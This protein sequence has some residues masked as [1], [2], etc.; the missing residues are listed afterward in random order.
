MEMTNR[1]LIAKGVNCRLANAKSH[2]VSVLTILSFVL[3]AGCSFT[4][5]ETAGVVFATM[6]SPGNKDHVILSS[7]QVVLCQCAEWQWTEIVILG[8]LV[9]PGG[10]RGSH[11]PISIMRKEY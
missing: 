7:R 1:W 10:I 6:C 11:R 5:I 3:I 8:H 2:L 4:H 9:H